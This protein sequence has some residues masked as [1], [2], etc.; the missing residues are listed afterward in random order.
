V[1]GEIFQPRHFTF[2]ILIAA[3]INETEPML[4]LLVGWQ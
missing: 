4:L 2:F 1:S 3:A